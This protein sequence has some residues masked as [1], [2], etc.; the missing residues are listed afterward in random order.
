[1]YYLIHLFPDL[2]KITIVLQVSTIYKAWTPG[3][4]NFF[5]KKQSEIPKVNSEN[6]SDNSYISCSKTT[7][8]ADCI[9][10]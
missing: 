9:W 7:V 5:S 1:M 10:E 8:S 3:N 2:G 4:L 6:L